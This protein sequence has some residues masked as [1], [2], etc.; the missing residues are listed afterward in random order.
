MYVVS[1][2][3]VNFMVSVEGMHIT[4]NF[5]NQNTDIIMQLYVYFKKFSG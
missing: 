2:E 1:Y 5:N 4:Q 3:K